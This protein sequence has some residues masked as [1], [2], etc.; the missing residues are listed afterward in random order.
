MSEENFPIE[1]NEST[2]R[3]ANH[4]KVVNVCLENSVMDAVTF[5]RECGA[6]RENDLLGVFSM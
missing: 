3:A 5:L 4:P 1:P 2:C 6:L